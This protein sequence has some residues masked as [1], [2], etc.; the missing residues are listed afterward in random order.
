MANKIKQQYGVKFPFTSNSINGYFLDT[1]LDVKSKVRS[2]LMHVIFTPKGQKIRDPQFG[3]DL[4]KQIFE[5][6]DNETWSQLKNSISDVIIKYL[7]SVTLKNIEMLKNEDDPHEVYIKVKYSVKSGGT[8][9]DDSL[10][11]TI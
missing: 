9:F 11:T 2:I 5:P 10:V 1:N 6:N 4:I 7:P 8:T 3:S